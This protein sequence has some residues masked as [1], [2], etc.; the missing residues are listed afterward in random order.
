[1][2][3]KK[4]KPPAR[5]LLESAK[6]H[7]NRVKK[8]QQAWEAAPKS[9]GRHATGDN[10]SAAQ[11]RAD[12]NRRGNTNAAGSRQGRNQNAGFGAASGRGTAGQAHSTH[13]KKYALGPCTK[14]HSTGRMKVGIV[15][16][17]FVPC[18]KCG[19]R[20]GAQTWEKR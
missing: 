16:V 14:C 9:D 15:N 8:A 18:R 13:K 3:N 11:K 20:P 12:A 6:G 1:M 2:A 10:R 4:F 19:G 7:E 5:G 17:R